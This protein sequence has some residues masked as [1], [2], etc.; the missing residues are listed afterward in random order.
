MS[1]PAPKLSAL[2]SAPPP[3][4]LLPDTM[5]NGNSIV[6]A[7]QKAAGQFGFDGTVLTSPT[8]TDTPSTA[9]KA[10]FGS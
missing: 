9:G 7:A 8:G 10:L 6:S 4:P 5:G 3:A 1:L 2:P